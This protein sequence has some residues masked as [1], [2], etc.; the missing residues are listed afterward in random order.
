[1]RVNQVAGGHSVVS[2]DQPTDSS[3]FGHKRL[4]GNMMISP[5]KLA[6]ESSSSIERN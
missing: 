4:R 2:S 3:G 1:M 5:C 6:D